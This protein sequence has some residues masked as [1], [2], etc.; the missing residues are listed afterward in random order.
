MRCYPPELR[1]E[2]GEE[3][4]EVFAESLEAEWSRDSVRGVLRVWRAVSHDL[5]TVVLPY[6]MARAAPLAAGIVLSLVFYGSMLLAIDPSS[7]CR[8]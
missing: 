5:A 1:V 3:M 2:F 4:A 6:R 7:H 8:K